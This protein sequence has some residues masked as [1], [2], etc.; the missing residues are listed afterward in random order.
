[1][2]L[3]E[4]IHTGRTKGWLPTIVSVK[5]NARGLGTAVW[6]PWSGAPGTP[7]V[8]PAPKF[9]DLYR[10]T[11]TDL[12]WYQNGSRVIPGP[13]TQQFTLTIEVEDFETLRIHFVHQKSHRRAIPLLF[14][15]DGWPGHFSEVSKLLP[16]L[17]DP[18]TD[19]PAFHVVAPSIPGFGFSPY[20]TRK[21]YNVRRMAETFNKLMKSLGY[22]YVAQGGDWG[23]PISRMPG[24]LY[25]QNCK[26][27]HVN[28]QTAPSPRWYQSP[29]SWTKWTLFGYSKDEDELLVSSKRFIAAETGYAVRL[30]FS[31]IIFNVTVNPAD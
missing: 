14:F 8:K 7:D 26:A 20:P 18:P 1:M 29:W 19:K 22:Q 3:S 27:V 12:E 10:T 21:G 25:P 4:Q 15:H 17:I 6:P 31:P 28:L 2:N 13:P 30:C 5:E 24:L 11:R 9:P 23:S 16:L